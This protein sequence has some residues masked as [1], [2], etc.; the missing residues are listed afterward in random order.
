MYYNVRGVPLTII[1]EK[2][3]LPG[4]VEPG[5]LMEYLKQID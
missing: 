2:Y 5:M 4:A 1:N 3:A